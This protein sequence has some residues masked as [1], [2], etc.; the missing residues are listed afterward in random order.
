MLKLMGSSTSLMDVLFA[1]VLCVSVAGEMRWWYRMLAV[2]GIALKV[3][4]VLLWLVQAGYSATQ[5]ER[6]T[7]THNTL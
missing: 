2:F 3:V 6:A 5:G 7:H 4:G 1:V